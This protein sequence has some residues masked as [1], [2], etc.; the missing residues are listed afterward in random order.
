MSEAIGREQVMHLIAQR[1]RSGLVPNHER[2]VQ[3]KCAP[4]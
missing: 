2:G 3:A 1:K 4:E